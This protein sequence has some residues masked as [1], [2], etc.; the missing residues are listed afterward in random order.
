MLECTMSLLGSKYLIFLATKSTEISFK[1][2]NSLP[3]LIVMAQ[4]VKPEA[5][6]YQLIFSN[7]QV[8]VF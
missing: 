5:L 4:S 7:S 2:L 6:P 3:K 8:V 1:D